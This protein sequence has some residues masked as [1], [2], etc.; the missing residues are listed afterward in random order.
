MSRLAVIFPGIGYTAD[1]P[2]L[3]YS[4]RIAAGHGYET[5]IMAYKGFPEKIRGDRSRMEQSFQIA[6]DQSRDMLADI[7]FTEYEDILFI[8]KSIGTIAAAKIASE[9]PARDRIRLV[10]YTPLEDTFSF[11]FGEAVAFTGGGDPWVGKSESR[12][13]HYCKK[14]GIPCFVIPDANHSLETNDPF[15]DMKEL[16]SVMNETDRFIG[17]ES[18][19]PEK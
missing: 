19:C 14:R 3:H 5:R 1:K 17:G 8:G 12:I 7:D 15:A 2:L 11:D 16:C 10:L 4:R 9:S 18:P 13:P 6:L